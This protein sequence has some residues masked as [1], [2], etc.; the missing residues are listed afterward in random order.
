MKKNEKNKSVKKIKEAPNNLK[1]NQMFKWVLEKL[2]FDFPDSATTKLTKKRLIKDIIPSLQKHETMSLQSMIQGTSKHHF[3]N[4]DENPNPVGKK[5]LE[6][7]HEFKKINKR[8]FFSFAIDS[9]KRL[10]G[11]M[12]DSNFHALWYDH[13][14]KIWPSNKQNT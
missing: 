1:K 13:Y 8:V 5:W 12:I 9:E 7:H 11:F 3:V 4:M 10:Y 14:H 6:Q 2:V